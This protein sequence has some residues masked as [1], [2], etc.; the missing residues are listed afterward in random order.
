MKAKRFWTELIL[1]GVAS[2]LALALLI[3][4][5]GAAGAAVTGQQEFSQPANEPSQTHLPADAKTYEGMVTCSRCRAKH[6]ASLGRTATDCALICVHGGAGFALIDG[7]KV[8]ELR[9]DLGKLKKFAGQRAA[10]VGVE[11]GNTITVSSVS[12]PS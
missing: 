2:A 12:A 1:L 4:T 9:G 5:L 11:Q 7:E 10:V 3:A 8:Y 6:P